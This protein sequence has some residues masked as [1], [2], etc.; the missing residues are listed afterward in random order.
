MKKII[1]LIGGI[2]VAAILVIA[3]T[4]IYQNKIIPELKTD[5]FKSAEKKTNFSDEKAF[6]EAV[7]YHPVFEYTGGTAQKTA[8]TYNENNQATSPSVKYSVLKDICVTD[9]KDDYEKTLAE[10]VE[11]NRIRNIEVTVSTP[12]KEETSD[13]SY[14]KENQTITFTK[15][16]IY[17]VKVTGKDAYNNRTETEFLVPVETSGNQKRTITGKK[18]GKIHEK[19]RDRRGICHCTGAAAILHLH[20][21][22]GCNQKNGI[23]RFHYTGN[24]ECGSKD[25]RG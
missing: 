13:A 16:G 12:D 1:Q 6:Y 19:Y 23:L 25:D 5:A 3:V 10:A 9:K 22:G 14:D 8:I 4:A 21:A 18:E 20:V 24:G 7:S 15:S 11:E 2:F 17:L